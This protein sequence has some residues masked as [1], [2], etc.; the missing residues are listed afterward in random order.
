MIT[1]YIPIPH[2]IRRLIYWINSM[3]YRKLISEFNGKVDYDVRFW[4]HGKFIIGHNLIVHNPGIDL[5]ECSKFVVGDKAVLEIGNNVGITQSAIHC[6]NQIIIEDNVK[7]GA[8]CLIMDSNFHSTN[9]TRRIK[10][11]DDQLDVKTSPIVIKNDVF[12]G[13]RCIITKGVTIGERTIIAAGSVVCNSIPSDC[14]AGGNPC[15]IIKTLV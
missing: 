1:N 4:I 3:K 10:A 15:K 13:A 8:G 14:I 12:I 11:L 2:F 5:V 9:W 6:Y 7:I